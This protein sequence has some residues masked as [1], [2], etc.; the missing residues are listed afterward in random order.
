MPRPSSSREMA[1]SEDPPRPIRRVWSPSEPWAAV[2]TRRTAR[3][4]AKRDRPQ[5]TSLTGGWQRCPPWSLSSDRTSPDDYVVG[6]IHIVK[7]F[8]DVMTRGHLV[9]VVVL[10][11]DPISVDAFE[12]DYMGLTNVDFMPVRHRRVWLDEGSIWAS[13]LKSAP[14]RCESKRR[15]PDGSIPDS[16]RSP[17]LRAS[18]SRSRRTKSSMESRWADD[19]RSRSGRSTSSTALG[20]EMKSAHTPNS[21]DWRRARDQP[22]LVFT[23]KDR[24]PTIGTALAARATS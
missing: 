10:R 6:Y 1:P 16:R 18:S 14:K 2:P 8:A 5:R 13:I 3:R 22:N 24:R 23:T 15:V 20:T 9:S 17:P 4:V 19:A 21:T 11:H 12:L 7:T